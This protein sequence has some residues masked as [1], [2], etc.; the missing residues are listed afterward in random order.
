ML[1]HME[2]SAAFARRI[3]EAIDQRSLEEKAGITRSFVARIMQEAEEPG[4]SLDD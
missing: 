3:V 1:A 2:R 4:T